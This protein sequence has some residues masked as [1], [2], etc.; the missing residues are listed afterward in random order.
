[1]RDS[2]F[3]KTRTPIA[4][5]PRRSHI[6]F[7]RQHE[8]PWVDVC[9][10]VDVTSLLDGAGP[11]VFVRCLHR[12]MGAL[13][14]VPQLLQRIEADELIEFDACSPSFTVPAPNGTFN[15]AIAEWAADI[16]TFAN[17][18]ESA[19]QSAAKHAELDHSQ[20]TRQ[21]LV[22]VTCLPWLDFS[23]IQH[24]RRRTDDD[25]TP[26]VAWGKITKQTTQ[27]TMPL[28]ISAHHGLVD[29]VHLA[30]FYEALQRG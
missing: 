8:H 10:R 24:P 18:V 13:N 4:D 15:F 23:S 16:E 12:V 5:L 26:R 6:D 25:F 11:G 17:N 9:C 19:K 21:D 27:I 1:M 3:P 7:Y 20:D 14:E 30:R 22:F 28:A 29:G 2:R